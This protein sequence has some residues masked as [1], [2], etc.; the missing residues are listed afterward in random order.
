[1]SAAALTERW[2]CPQCTAVAT[3]PTEV[4][5][6]EAASGH[7]MRRAGERPADAGGGTLDLEA[8]EAQIERANGAVRA[9]CHGEQRWTM[10]VPARPEEDPDLVIG[11][12]LHAAERLVVECRRLREREAEARRIIEQALASD[13]AQRAEIARLAEVLEAARHMPRRTPGPSDSVETLHEYRLPAWAVWQMDRALKA[14][15]GAPA[16]E[17][18][19]PRGFIGKVR[20]THAGGYHP[21]QG[22]VVDPTLEQAAA[23]G[24]TP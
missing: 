15:D 7:H 20:I 10:S 13:E 18:P 22:H 14:Y 1:M 2:E 12:A 23:R 19:T 3:C 24:G 4:Q 9:L 6:H 8:V 21:D 11:Q 5:Q 17:T 16:D